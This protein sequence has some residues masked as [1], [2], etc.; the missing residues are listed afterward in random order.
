MSVFNQNPYG[1]EVNG[2]VA[3][4]VL[5]DPSGNS[6]NVSNLTKCMDIFI[7]ADDSK[8]QPSYHEIKKG[9]LL[10]TNLNVTNNMSAIY[11]WVVPEHNNTQIVILCRKDSQPTLEEYDFTQ[12]V[13]SSPK[14]EN[15]SEASNSSKS[16]ESDLSR[17]L[18][19]IDN[20]DLN[21]TAAGA[22]FFGF[23]Y[24][25]SIQEEDQGNA[26]ETARFN[27]T[28]VQLACKYLNTT[29]KKWRSDGCKVSLKRLWKFSCNLCS[30]C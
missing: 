11:V 20:D 22:W 12:T 29:S 3:E 17:F 2:G 25:G 10:V 4:L 28:I 6:K 26:P 21:Q 18:M 19:F 14:S 24:N 27:L 16:S 1:G 8:T 7:K 23:Y 9:D 30:G 15:A 5:T 13:P